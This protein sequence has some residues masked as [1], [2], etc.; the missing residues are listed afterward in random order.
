VRLARSRA[1]AE[2]ESAYRAYETARDQVR[3][4]E[5]GILRQADESR[6]AFDTSGWLTP[7]AA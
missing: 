2:V 5:A 1:L 7:A 4:Y 6:G 3:A